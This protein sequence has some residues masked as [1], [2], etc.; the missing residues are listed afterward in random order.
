ME[1]QANTTREQ[2]NN[3]NIYDVGWRPSHG[4]NGGVGKKN[5]YIYFNITSFMNVH[6]SVLTVILIRTC[7]IVTLHCYAVEKLF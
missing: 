4:E 3:K 5:I 7:D 2:S 1:A 6:K